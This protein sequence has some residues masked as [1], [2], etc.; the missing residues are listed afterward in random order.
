MR[1]ANCFFRLELRGGGP[2]VAGEAQEEEFFLSTCVSAI[3]S[4]PFTDYVQYYT[5]LAKET[6]HIYSS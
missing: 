1:P 3:S 4:P 2:G 6:M 5:C